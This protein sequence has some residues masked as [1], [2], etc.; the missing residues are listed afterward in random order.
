[1]N[2]GESLKFGTKEIAAIAVM[3]ALTTVATIRYKSH[4][5]PQADILI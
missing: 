3:G 4:S 2:M 5:L 1:M